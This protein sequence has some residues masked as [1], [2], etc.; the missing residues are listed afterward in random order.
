MD[1]GVNPDRKSTLISMMNTNTEIN[2]NG[3]IERAT[4]RSQLT[5]GNDTVEDQAVRGRQP[6]TGTRRRKYS[7]EDNR[8]SM[9]CSFESRSDVRGYGRR[10]HDIWKE[11][12]GFYTDEQRLADQVRTIKRND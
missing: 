5:L 8:A 2:R 1:K 9:E 6:V 4:E 12:G 3:V 7:R 10:M 11:R